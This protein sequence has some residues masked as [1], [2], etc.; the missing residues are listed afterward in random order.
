MDA[1]QMNIAQRQNWMAV[2]AHSVAQELASRWEALKIS[3]NYQVIRQPETGLVQIQARMGATG[4]R[5]FAG[6]ATLTRAVVQLD[7][8]IYG[9]SYLLGRDKAHAE[10]CAVIDALMQDNAYFQTLQETLIAPLAANREQR[11]AKRRAEVNSSRVD[12]FTLVRG[13]NA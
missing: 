5:F 11:L 1:P 9:Y 8:G 12:F 10:R 3:P 13:D 6:D 7:N 4:Q 2:L